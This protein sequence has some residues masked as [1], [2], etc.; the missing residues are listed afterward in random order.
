M[1]AVGAMEL[2]TEEGRADQDAEKVRVAGLQRDELPG[3][4]ARFART[5]VVAHEPASDRVGSRIRRLG[6]IK[7][8]RSCDLGACELWLAG[9]P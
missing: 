9:L 7:F 3:E 8:A 6:L 4:F 2:V 1:V 5:T